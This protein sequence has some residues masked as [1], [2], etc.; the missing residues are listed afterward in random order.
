LDYAT[1]V[2]GDEGDS[3]WMRLYD[4]TD[5]GWDEARAIAVDQSGS[6]VVTGTAWS[7][8]TWLDCTTVKYDS[9]GTQLWVRTYN[10][11]SDSADGAWDIAVDD[12]GRIYVAG[13]SYNIGTGWDYVAIK[14]NSDGLAIWTR[15][16]HGGR[17]EQARG[18]AV[19][20]SGNVYVT[21]T[22]GTVKYDAGG[23]LQWVRGGIRSAVEVDESGDVYVTGSDGTAKYDSDGN[24]LWNGIWG[25]PDITIDAF[26]NVY[27]C[28]GDSNYVTLKYLP[29]G[30]TAWL[31]EYGGPLQDQ[32][33]AITV[34]DLGSNICVTGTSYDSIS[35]FDYATVRY[36]RDGN[37][38]WVE[39]FNGPASLYDEAYAIAI[40]NFGNV[41]V[42]GKSHSAFGEDFTTIKYVQLL[43]GDA[44]GNG[45]IEPGDIVY[46][47]NYLFRGGASPVPLQAGDCNCD[48]EVGPGDVV[49]L[50]NFL[51]RGW[52]PP[53][54]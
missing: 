12:S 22:G 20:D 39:R 10:G 32:P 43:R 7:F 5:G 25:G 1:I 53:S 54:C 26:H 31:R 30:D 48:G 34:D 9:N 3:L 13:E 24:E 35:R 41:C 27:I 50:I 42:T 15:R 29:D 51:F 16:Y 2:Y 4:G 28:G 18:I 19:D 36:D 8:E 33:Y 46:L 37:Q 47:V 45:E 52:S 40:D 38:L 21:G 49:Y 14:Y 11:P 23:I 44:N 17:D 6:V